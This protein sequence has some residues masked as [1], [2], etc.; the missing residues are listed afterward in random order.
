MCALGAVAFQELARGVASHFSILKGPLSVEHNFVNT[1]AHLMWVVIGGLVLYL[2]W[3]KQ[4]KVCKSANL[5]KAS[6]LDAKSLGRQTSHFVNG[7]W[8]AE[9]LFI[10]AIVCQNLGKGTP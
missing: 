7:L 6:V 9:Q 5:N 2:E 4:N 3:V 1:L 8:Q 10:S